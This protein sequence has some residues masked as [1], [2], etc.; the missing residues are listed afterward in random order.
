MNSDKL[1]VMKGITKKFPGVVALENVDFDLE[2]GEVHVL[3]GENGAGKSTLIKILSGAYKKDE[4]N[5][6]LYGQPTEITSPRQARELGI[7]TIYQ[8]FNLVPYMSVAENIFLGIEALRGNIVKT[9]DKKLMERKALEALSRLRLNINPRSKI[10]DLGIAEQQMVEIVKA[11]TKDSKIYIFDEPTAVL[12]P[13]EIGELFRIIK[14]LKN[15]GAGIIYISHRLEEI[16][17]IGDRITV[18][19]DGHVVGT[20]YASRATTDELVRMM[21]GREIPTRIFE[22]KTFGEELLR[23][24]NLSCDRVSGVTIY[25]RRGEI[26][27]LAGLVG[28][29]RTELAK[30]LFGVNPWFRGAVYV[31]GRPVKITSPREAIRLGIAYL[32]ESRKEE[33]L[34]LLM[35]VA[36]N[37]NLPVLRRCASWGCLK[38]RELFANAAMYKEKLRIKTPSLVQP[39]MYLSGGNQQKVVLAKWLSSECDILIF[40][41]PTR[42]I[43]VGA[44]EEIRDLI[45][46][47]ARQGKGVLLISSELPEVLTLC[48]RIYVMCRGKISGE[49]SREEANEERILELAFR[50]SLGKGGESG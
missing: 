26:V 37:V 21:T 10:K 12:T 31:K 35:S 49:L 15:S 24:E 48:D 8:E 5:I 23:V 17:L 9:L 39:V 28:S 27:G 45:V 4:G 34:V 47:L 14:E 43:D 29:G 11:L 1:L 22:E 13:N 41:E 7:S 6:F 40:D 2:R 50:G 20:V 38:H 42:G 44:K 3:L 36:D 33:G 46:D 30:A 32:P 25:L 18:L 19:R 16:P